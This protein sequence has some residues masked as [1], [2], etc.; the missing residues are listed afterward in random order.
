MSFKYAIYKCFDEDVD[1]PTATIVAKLNVSPR[2]VQA[3]RKEYKEVLIRIQSEKKGE[4]VKNNNDVFD[5]G[6]DDNAIIV[7]VNDSF[8]ELSDNDIEIIN[9]ANEGGWS[10]K[11]ISEYTRFS[12][13]FIRDTL[14][15]VYP[16]IKADVLDENDAT[17]FFKGSKEHNDH[18]ANLTQS[19]LDELDSIP[20]TSTPITTNKIVKEEEYWEIKQDC[21]T[22]CSKVE[23]NV[24]VFMNIKS[25]RK[26]M[27]YMKWA[28]AREWLA[29]LVGKME[30]GKY[31]IED[32]YLPDQRTSS[33]LVDK[34]DTT[35]FNR[36]SIV[37]VIHSHHEMGAGDVDNPSFS[38]HDAEFINSNHNLSLLAGKDGTGFKIVG[39]ARA[40]TPCGA[41]IQIKALVKALVEN[42]EEDKAL[43][44]EFLEKT[45]TQTQNSKKTQTQDTWKNKRTY[46]PGPNGLIDIRGDGFHF[47]K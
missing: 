47:T 1:M 29:Y 31:I 7:P 11:D 10:I 18:H 41:F 44:D 2:Y 25:R 27:L 33:V 24:D 40:K 4:K 9:I 21:V 3:L 34:V 36:L 30:N 12:E 43:K 14:N 8:M 46:F 19:I 39:I 35:E 17:V 15:R 26:A 16:L 22:A 37:G 5:T 32:L 42:S 28:G 6:I 45:M 20:N 38:G 13:K 23:K